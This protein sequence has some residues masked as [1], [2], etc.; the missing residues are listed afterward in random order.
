[1]AR[2]TVGESTAVLPR[3]PKC[4]RVENVRPLALGLVS[5]HAATVE[6]ECSACAATFKPPVVVRGFLA[7]DVT[8]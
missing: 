3:C 6:Y 1:M 4:F 5:G 2:L 8:S 7:R